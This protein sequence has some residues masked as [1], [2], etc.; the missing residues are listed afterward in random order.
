VVRALDR[1]RTC[2]LLL[3]RQPLYPLSYEGVKLRVSD[4]ARTR[5]LLCHKQA[6]CQLSYTHHAAHTAAFSC[7]GASSP[8]PAS[9]R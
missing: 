3:R 8:I 9:I 6:L 4:G 1:N 5:D 2:D 7:G